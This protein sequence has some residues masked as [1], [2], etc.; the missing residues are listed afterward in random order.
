MSN[1]NKAPRTPAPVFIEIWQTSSSMKE[2]C[3]RTGLK[4]PSAYTRARGYR[5]KGIPLK[6]FKKVRND[7]NQLRDL[8]M[9][10]L[11]EEEK[12]D[13]RNQES[14]DD[15]NQNDAFENVG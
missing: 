7:W 3:E 12:S 9:S 13:L 6:Q 1:T 2:V 10:F 5:A 4:E 15:I 8:A 14:Q 11:S